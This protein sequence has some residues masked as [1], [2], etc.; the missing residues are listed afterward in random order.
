MKLAEEEILIVRE[1][2]DRYL[3]RPDSNHYFS[4]KHAEILLNLSNKLD[5][6]FKL[7]KVEASYFYLLTRL[8]IQEFDKQYHFDSIV[9]WV[10]VSDRV[11]DKMKEKDIL[12]DILG[13]TNKGFLKND[14]N[15][16]LNF[17]S[18]NVLELI[19]KMKSSNLILLSAKDD[20]YKI[21]FV[22]N[23]TEWL[24]FDIK[25]GISI[26]NVKFRNLESFRMLKE[27]FESELTRK[28]AF[29]IIL[30]IKN[31]ERY[32]GDNIKFFLEILK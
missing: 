25:L 13:K 15:Y 4:D 26:E 8:V 6:V 31:N 21:C 11:K 9:D 14:F 16:N 22:Y 5:S 17:R 3:T 28:E 18:R 27:S 7:T 30:N 32:Y 10:N 12:L 20:T 24:M 23:L 29:E 2:I 1:I 19:D